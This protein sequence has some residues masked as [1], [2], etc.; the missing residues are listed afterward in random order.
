MDIRWDTSR[1]AELAV[2]LD[3]KSRALAAHR[4]DMH[5]LCSRLGA[6]V[7]LR[8]LAIASEWADRRSHDLMERRRM[9]SEAE[10]TLLWH[11]DALPPVEPAL[12]R[13][14]SRST[15][16]IEADLDAAFERLARLSNGVATTA[17][18]RAELRCAELTYELGVAQRNEYLLAESLPHPDVVAAFTEVI[19]FLGYQIARARPRPTPDWQ[20]VARMVDEIRRL[21]DESWFSDVGRGDLLAI[22]QILAGLAPVEI[23]AV[24]SRLNTDELYRWFHELDGVRGGNLSETEEAE[25]FA[26]IARSAGAQAL[27]RLANAEAGTR[28]GAIAAAVRNEA[29]LEVALEFIEICAAE[30]AQSDDALVATLAGLAGLE[31]RHRTVAATAL[32]EAGLLAQLGAAT[33]AFIRRQSIERNSPLIVEFF[34]GLLGAIGGAALTVADLS[35]VG[36]VDRHRFR[37]A[38]SS[39]GGVVGLA[40]H[41]PIEFAEIVLDIETLRQ[42]PARWAGA[43]SSEF[44]SAGIGRL[45][46]LG[47][48]GR[49][50]RIASRWLK[51]VGKFVLLETER[52]SLRAQ[53]VAA[54]LQ[55]IGGA[56]SAAAVRDALDDLEELED[57]VEDLEESVEGLDVGA[58]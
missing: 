24:L 37:E 16:H 23:D 19:D 29:P 41:D 12:P 40:F 13:L 25:L 8:H 15:E 18:N 32:A 34:E 52:V 9:L 51:R 4:L 14:Q 11:L 39:M 22:Q 54:T 6:A 17:G 36:I 30:A 1:M 49:L 47:R 35:L 48:L 50:A 53:H 31:P 58:P 57:Q 10:E 55:E 7:G 43:V 42:N 2:S 46:R 27:F 56:A 38:W 20:R 5:E 33:D 28:F 26:V 3:N 44:V 45:A 21:L